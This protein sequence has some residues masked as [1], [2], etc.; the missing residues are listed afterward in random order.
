LVTINNTKKEKIIFACLSISPMLDKEV[1]L[2]V[3]SIRTFGGV[4]S[5]QPI[6]VLVP[7]GDINK[8]AE[9][10][11]END[12]NI[13]IIPFKIDK[14]AENFPLSEK[15]F[16]AA[17]AEKLAALKSELLVWM[18]SEALVL[19]SLDELIID[20]SKD[21][22]YRPVDITNIGL[23]VSQNQGA[24]EFGYHPK[25]SDD[26]VSRDNNLISK[27]WKTL[28]QKTDV[29]EDKIYTAQTT[30]DENEIQ[31]YFNAGLF[32]TR[33]ET[34]L[35]MNWCSNFQRLFLDQEFIEFY[36]KDY[37]FKL[38]MHQA[39]LACT[40]LSRV[41]RTRV[42]ELPYTISYP[43]CLHNKYPENKRLKSLNDIITCRYYDF[44][45]YKDWQTKILVHEPLT[46]WIN[47][48]I[49]EALL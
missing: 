45:E 1:N 32:I 24:V 10:E 6:W 46:E 7:N 22:A 25:N 48:N 43:I 11:R 44:F 49:F 31:A 33:P 42:Y 40:V 3:K 28:Y 14:A 16:G 12:L 4:L 15:V 36:E 13:K 5:N 2:L 41:N 18:D 21:F 47:K 34:G 35:L 8:C 39:V 26:N 19:N 9:T 23:I 30:I 27:F 38:F 29:T 37:N 20:N 17:H